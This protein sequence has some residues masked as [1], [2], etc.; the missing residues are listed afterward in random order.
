M[1]TTN[2]IN[3]IDYATAAKVS[4]FDRGLVDV[5]AS[6]C[7]VHRWLLPTWLCFQFANAILPPLCKDIPLIF[8]I[9]PIIILLIL[10]SARP[11]K[12]SLQGMM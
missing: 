1:D 3:I 8:L 2:N 10:Y 6:L 7:G 12:I 11:K 9:Y 5:C 4:L